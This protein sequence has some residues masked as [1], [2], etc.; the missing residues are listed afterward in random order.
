MR[1]YNSVVY[2]PRLKHADEAH[3]PPSLGKGVFAW[4]APLWKITEKDMVQIVGMDAAVF[5]RF[6][7]MCRDLFIV[8]SIIGCAVLIPIN[9]NYSVRFPNDVWLAWLGP[10]TVFGTPQWAQVIV[11]WL[12]NLTICGFLWWNY[13]KVL[14]LRRT[15]F[16]SNDYQMSLHA[17]T[18][19]VRRHPRLSSPP[20]ARDSEQCC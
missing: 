13:R 2:A 6:T 18:L 20:D 12:F 5:M 19:M 4:V 10:S 1:P 8:L 15:Y 9:Y 7:V 11:A 16:E 17:R 14:Q 3:A